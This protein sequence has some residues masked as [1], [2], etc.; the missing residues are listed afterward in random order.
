MLH[1]SRNLYLL[2]TSYEEQKAWLQVEK[3][4]QSHVNDNRTLSDEGVIGLTDEILCDCDVDLSDWA[5]DLIKKSGPILRELP[6]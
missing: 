1:K 5:K 3:W 4:L 6:D 2:A